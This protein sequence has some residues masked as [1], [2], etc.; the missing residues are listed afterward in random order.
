MADK[1][2]VS[3]NGEQREVDKGITLKELFQTSGSTRDSSAPLI[4]AGIVNNR[5][6]ELTYQLEEDCGFAI[7][8]RQVGKV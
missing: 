4:V 3:L 1:I 6:R 2:L 5:I 8:S 7:L